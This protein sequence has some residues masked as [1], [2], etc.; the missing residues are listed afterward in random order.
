MIVSAHRRYGRCSAGATGG[1]MAEDGR[2]KGGRT[3][4]LSRYLP[5]VEG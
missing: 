5:F 4:G 2:L 3:A 1:S